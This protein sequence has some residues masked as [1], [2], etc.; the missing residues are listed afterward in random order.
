MPTQIESARFASISALGKALVGKKLRVA[1][2]YVKEAHR[3]QHNP[4]IPLP[5]LLGYDAI[6]GLIVLLDADGKHT[7]VVD[8]RE[9]LDESS[10]QWVN[11]RLGTVMVVG[12]VEESP[13]SGN[14]FSA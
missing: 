7:V 1:G 13:V 9:V 6:H 4:L 14:V 8:V 3:P 5:R 12:Y 2:R 10:S 11:E